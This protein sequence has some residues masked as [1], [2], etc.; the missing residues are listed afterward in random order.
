MNIHTS[1]GIGKLWTSSETSPPWPARHT[2]IS[3]P[4]HT[5]S[6]L[7]HISPLL[8]GVASTNGSEPGSPLVA[9]CCDTKAQLSIPCP[10]WS[11]G[12]AATLAPAANL[13]TVYSIGSTLSLYRKR[14][15]KRR[16][17]KKFSLYARRGEVW[18]NGAISGDGTCYSHTRTQ[19]SSNILCTSVLLYWKDWD[20]DCSFVWHRCHITSTY[21]E[22]RHVR[23]LKDVLSDLK[24]GWEK[25]IWCEICGNMTNPQINQPNLSEYI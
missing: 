1:R 4:T 13:Y 5:S 11:L 19:C 8:G 3:T 22:K 25:K 12:R 16:V 6:S 18:R 24:S 23:D 10:V 21:L 2:S 17:D 7:K 15:W 9:V 20:T 14:G